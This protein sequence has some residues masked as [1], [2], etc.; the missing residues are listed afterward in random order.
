MNDTKKHQSPRLPVERLVSCRD[1][2]FKNMCKAYPH[3]MYDQWPKEFVE[4]AKG[5]LPGI[6]EDEIKRV[7]KETEGN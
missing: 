5:V 3:E 2:V 7:L 4:Y 6:S 1:G